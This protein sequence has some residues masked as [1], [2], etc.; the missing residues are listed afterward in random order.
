VGVVGFVVMVVWWLR[1]KRGKKLQ[2]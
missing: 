1:W 2:V